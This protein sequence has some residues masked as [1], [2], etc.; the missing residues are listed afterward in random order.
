MNH[1]IININIP[2]WKSRL[3][4]RTKERTTGIIPSIRSSWMQLP[5]PS[6]VKETDSIIGTHSNI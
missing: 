2:D 6:S 3:D 4:T 1:I 5:A